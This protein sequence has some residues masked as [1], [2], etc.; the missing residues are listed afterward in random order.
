MILGERLGRDKFYKY[1]DAFG[2]GKPTNIDVNFEEKGSKRPINK[3]GPVELAN[4]SFGQ[5]ITVT[6]IQMLTAFSAI[7]NDGKLMEPHLVKKIQTTDSNGNIELIKE[8]QPKMVKQ[9]IDAG[10]AKKLR[11]YLETVISVGGGKKAYIEGYHIAGKT[12]TAQK[13]QNG[14]YVGGKYVAS[15]L[16]MAPVDKPQY[17]L[18]VCIDEPDPSNYYAGQIAAPLAGKIFKDIFDSKNIPP[19]NG[20]KPTIEVIIPGVAGLSQGAAVSKLKSVGLQGEING[21]GTVVTDIYPKPGISV[22]VGS[23]V[24]LY[25]GNGQTYNNKVVVPDLEGMSVD[26]VTDVLNS[27]GLKLAKSG[28]GYAVEQDPGVGQE[29]EKGSIVSVDFDVYGD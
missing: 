3:V 14:Q 26:E 7:A 2:F 9:V 18:F 12:G 11:Q 10:I 4:L 22:K 16:G 23:K 8:V 27:L 19:D 28:D 13:A 6:P 25:M 5:G 15:F 20:E 17:A 1:V 24:I 29:V 21:K